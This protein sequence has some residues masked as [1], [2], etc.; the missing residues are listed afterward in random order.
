MRGRLHALDITEERRLAGTLAGVLYLTGAATVLALL[1]LPGAVTDHW[2]VVLVCSAVS[3]AWGLACLLLIRWETVNP[4]LSHFSSFMG[5]P[6][7]AVVMS[8]TG[9]AQSP[10]RFYLFFIV[11][12]VAY[13]YPPREAV[14]YLMGCIVVHALPLFY[15]GSAVDAHLP[16]ELVIAGATYLV[17]GAGILAGKRLL[18]ELR[19]AALELSRHDSLT[20]LCNRRAMMELLNR[21]VGGKRAADVTGLLVVDLDEFKDANTLFGHPG[22]DRVLRATAEALT[23]SARGDDMVARL[24]GDEFAIIARG[25]DRRVMEKLAQ[26]VVESVRS[27]DRELAMPG[28]RLSA[29]VGWAIYPGDGTTVDELMAAADDALQVA[30]HTGKD[31]AQSPKAVSAPS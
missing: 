15:D 12:Y 11:V 20:G 5:L 22:G 19:D 31:R 6:L 7:T 25:V 14:P 30:K 21:H 17:L 9:G 18:V 23:L 29:S 16:G 8:A 3:I 13:F 2:K 10:A 1:V 28:F 24:G 26:R 4:L 27:A